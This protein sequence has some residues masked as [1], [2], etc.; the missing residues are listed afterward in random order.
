MNC[1]FQANE[2]VF[3]Q[4]PIIIVCKNRNVTKRYTK[5]YDTT[6]SLVIHIVCLC[7]PT[8]AHSIPMHWFENIQL[9]ISSN[10]FWKKK[11]IECYVGIEREKETKEWQVAQ[12]KM[13]LELSMPEVSKLRIDGQF[14]NGVNRFLLISN[15]LAI[16]LG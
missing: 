11:K 5:F 3:C 13:W 8:I 2:I 6:G 15:V 10:P 7:T 4:S 16:A 14:A 1:R 9:Y 12:E